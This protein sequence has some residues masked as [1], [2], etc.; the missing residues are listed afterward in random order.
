MALAAGIG[1]DAHGHIHELLGGSWSSQADDYASF[2]AT[3]IVA[4]FLHTMQVKI[5]MYQTTFVG[6]SLVFNR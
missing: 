4:P 2:R 5:V 6:F 1:K 3:D